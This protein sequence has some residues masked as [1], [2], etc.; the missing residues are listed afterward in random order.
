MKVLAW[1]IDR[2]SI[3]NKIYCQ[4][5]IPYWYQKNVK[6]SFLLPEWYTIRT[7]PVEHQYFPHKVVTLL[8]DLIEEK[9]CA[10]KGCKS[11]LCVLH[12]RRFDLL[13]KFLVDHGICT[14]NGGHDLTVGRIF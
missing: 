3:V 12:I 13:K 9:S 2:N 11:D 14:H 7:I 1:Y 4:T 5:P 8:L 10:L 6:S